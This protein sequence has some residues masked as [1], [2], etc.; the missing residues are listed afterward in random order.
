MSDLSDLEFL[1]IQERIELYKND[2]AFSPFNAAKKVA[3]VAEAYLSNFFDAEKFYGKDS[4]T[5]GVIYKDLC[6]DLRFAVSKELSRTDKSP[7]ESRFGNGCSDHIYITALSLASLPARLEKYCDFMPQIYY[8]LRMTLGNYLDALI[9]ISGKNGKPDTDR[10]NQYRKLKKE[11][12][13]IIDLTTP[14]CGAISIFLDQYGNSRAELDRLSHIQNCKSN[15]DARVQM[16]EIREEFL[17]DEEYEFPD[18]DSE[19]NITEFNYDDI[20]PVAFVIDDDYEVCYDDDFDDYYDE[21]Y[22]D[23]CMELRADRMLSEYNPY[24][25]YLEKARNLPEVSAQSPESLY[26][27]GND[28]PNLLADKD[29]SPEGFRARIDAAELPADFRAIADELITPESIASA[30]KGMDGVTDK[31]CRLLI[32]PFA[33]IG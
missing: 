26:G 28:N 16:D 5:R 2:M 13:E 24:A 23:E 27:M 20:A 1:T 33:E 21:D 22:D 18:E 15:L 6:S 25:Y 30:F 9:D 17:D 19:E 14:L 12:S 29:Y 31:L 4:F 11:F 10:A 7:Y 8:N 3:S 32:E